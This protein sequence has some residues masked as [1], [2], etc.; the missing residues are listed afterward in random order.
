VSV[1]GGHS[2]LYTPLELSLIAQFSLSFKVPATSEATSEEIMDY[3]QVPI[4]LS[5]S[6]FAS[7][8]NENKEETTQQ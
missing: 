5:S 2:T 3:R 6:I 4:A 8:K 1:S 7:N